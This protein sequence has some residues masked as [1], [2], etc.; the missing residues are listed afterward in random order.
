MKLQIA[1]KNTEKQKTD[2]LEYIAAERAMT[3]AFGVKPLPQRGGGSIPIVSLFER[4]L[5]VKTVMMGFGLDSD[6]I[7][8][9]NEKYGLFNFYKGIE[10]IPL[11]HRHYAELKNQY[12]Q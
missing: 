11:F 6:N 5:G 3:E 12:K 10:T 1:Y 2:S 8:S 7:H 4:V 9:P